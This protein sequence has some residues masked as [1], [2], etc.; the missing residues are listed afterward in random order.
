MRW[1]CFFAVNTGLWR[2]RISRCDVLLAVSIRGFVPGV[3]LDGELFS[4]QT[5]TTAKIHNQRLNTHAHTSTHERV[6]THKSERSF[7]CVETGAGMWLWLTIFQVLWC[8]TVCTQPGRTRDW[9]RSEKNRPVYNNRP[10]WTASLEC[11]DTTSTETGDEWTWQKHDY[12]V[13]VNKHT[14]C[15]SFLLFC[16]IHL[17]PYD[18]KLIIYL[19]F[20]H[21]SFCLTNNTL[22][23]KYMVFFFYN[24]I[25][26]FTIYLSCR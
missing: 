15:I 2:D 23:L 8:N 17:N 14:V 9:S 12:T 20:I 24:K 7:C 22:D 25:C 16:I 11:R 13:R 21:F 3:R 6:H 10:T 26:S 18:A 19:L 1:M 5:Q 4:S